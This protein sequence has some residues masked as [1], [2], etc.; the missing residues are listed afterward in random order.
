[1]SKTPELSIFYNTSKAQFLGISLFLTL[2]L[3]VFLI[4][5]NIWAIALMLVTM[6]ALVFGLKFLKISRVKNAVVVLNESGIT[7]VREVGIGSEGKPGCIPWK[8]IGNIKTVQMAAGNYLCINFKDEVRDSY[9]RGTND[10]LRM[11]IGGD[12]VISLSWMNFNPSE[13]AGVLKKNVSEV[14]WNTAAAKAP[15]RAVDSHLEAGPITKHKPLNAAMQIQA[16]MG[17]SASRK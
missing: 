5:Q 11:A 16:M 17:T 12:F 9:G 4:T 1:M 2:P 8:D 15:S 3:N 14:Q 6:P 7:D 10:N 13:V